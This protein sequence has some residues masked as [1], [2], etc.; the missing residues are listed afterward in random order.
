[1]SRVKLKLDE[2]LGTRGRAVFERFG[3]DVLTVS[4][5]KLQSADDSRRSLP[6]R[7]PCA[8]YMAVSG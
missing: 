3:Y 6:R 2:N 1:M 8:I 7:L 4:E 5:Q